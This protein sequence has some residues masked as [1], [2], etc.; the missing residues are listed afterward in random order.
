MANLSIFERIKIQL[1]NTYGREYGKM[2]IHTG[3]IG[4]A[5]SSVAQVFAI[6]FNEK[7]PK[8]QKMFMI[9]QEI[10]DAAINIVSFYAVT[11]TLSTLANKAVK[12]G[13][14]LPGN[15]SKYFN[16]TLIKRI[17][18]KIKN[19][20]KANFD[21]EKYVRQMPPKLKKNYH[22]FKNG[23]DVLATLTGSIISCNIL[24]PVF[25]N[26]Y[27]SHKQQKNIAKYNNTLQASDKP[28]NKYSKYYPLGKNIYSFTNRGD[29]KI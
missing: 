24:T 6:A 27:A 25:R 1:F 14:L 18:N 12:C 26:I 8:E 10:A 9:P 11:R 19:L 16:T 5:M 4:W 22:N 15:V 20:G 13:K 3:I 29:L 21:V 17:P 2:L 28:Q 23:I 7:I